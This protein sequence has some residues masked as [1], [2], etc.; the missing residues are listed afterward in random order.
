MA[1]GLSK[2]TFCN[3]IVFTFDGLIIIRTQFDEDYFFSLL[4]KLSSFCKDFTLPKLVTNVK[5]CST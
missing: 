2:I 3:F 4:Q 5:N 1:M